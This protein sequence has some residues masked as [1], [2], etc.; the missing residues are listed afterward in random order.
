AEMTATGGPT[1][2]RAEPSAAAAEGHDLTPSELKIALLV[3]QGM[4]NREVAASLFL[5][6]K[7]VE[8]HLSHVYRKLDVRSRTQLARLFAEERPAAGVA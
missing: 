1:G 7:T 2:P 4:T 8:H 6:P 3:A 5:S